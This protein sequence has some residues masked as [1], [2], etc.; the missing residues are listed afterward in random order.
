MSG[1]PVINREGEGLEGGTSILLAHEAA[2]SD[3]ISS[4][5][6]AN[7]PSDDISNTCSTR[8]NSPSLLEPT[9]AIMQNDTLFAG[10]IE[11]AGTEKAQKLSG[12]YF[13]D[14]DGSSSSMEFA[15]IGVYNMMGTS[16]TD[17]ILNVSPSIESTNTAKA[18]FDDSCRIK[19]TPLETTSSSNAQFKSWS[20][21]E[22]YCVCN[23]EQESC[24]EFFE[25]TSEDMEMLELAQ[26]TTHSQSFLEPQRGVH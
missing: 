20:H 12:G 24:D 4:K 26:L 5:P 15:K 14:N 1:I 19:D 9:V 2:L 8:S 7:K 18:E 17:E 13:N 23:T 10:E 25:V 22:D 11:N 16:Q 3:E 6:V 21:F